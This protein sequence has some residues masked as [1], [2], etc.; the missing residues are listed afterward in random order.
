MKCLIPIILGSIIGYFTNWLA[1]K[2][3]FR[4]Y[5]EKKVFGISLPFTP[6][7]IPKEQKRIAKSVG[8]TVQDHLLSH[9]QI[10]KT[11]MDE[12]N[13]HKILGLIREKID[14]LDD[15]LDLAE[16]LDFFL[17]Q[18]AR[19]VLEDSKDKI[20]LYFESLVNEDL[21]YRLEN[22]VAR[23]LRTSSYKNRL[24][25][26]I[27][28]Y[29]EEEFPGNL[30]IFLENLVG[31]DKRSLRELLGDETYPK[32]EVYIDE[33][34]KKLSYNFRKFLEQDE[35]KSKLEASLDNIIRE[36]LSGFILNFVSLDKIREKVFKLLGNYLR[37]DK[38]PDDFSQ[39]LKLL[40][41]KFLDK[42]ISSLGSNLKDLGLVSS[43]EDLILERKDEIGSLI[44][45]RLDN[46]NQE[47]LGEKISQGL[48]SYLQSKEARN[49]ILRL[50]VSLEKKVLSIKVKPYLKDLDLNKLSHK[51]FID[52]GPRIFDL[53]E[54][55]S[56]INISKLV[57]DNINSFELD[58]A[59]ELILDIASKE[60][61]AI[62]NLGGVLGGFIGLLSL[63]LNYL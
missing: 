52:L 37:G 45:A 41:N 3:L 13:L 50:I 58:F 33:N 27:M 60:L 26:L 12:E 5:E 53:E 44:E 32:L 29:F 55:S 9:E 47:V 4:P 2:M 21:K 35:L 7:L 6:G 49:L 38:Y 10:R 63:L 28:T 22:E 19:G 59:E 15:D 46:I 31:K 56:I 23:F 57:E 24:K 8:D 51:L 48:F 18:E 42:E 14:R 20:L 34:N 39:A 54:I 17:G 61:R 30:E 36:N 16:V 43:L 62:T 1:I 25:D 11:L 40:L